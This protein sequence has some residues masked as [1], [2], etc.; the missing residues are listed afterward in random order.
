ML[1]GSNTKKRSNHFARNSTKRPSKSGKSG[2]F[3]VRRTKNGRRTRRSCTPIGGS[4]GLPGRKKSTLPSPPRPTLNICNDKPYQD[5]KKV[6]VAGPFTVE[7]IS[8]HRVLNVGADD[9][10][11][12]PLESGKAK[13][14]SGGSETDFVTMILEN[15]NTAG[16]QQAHKEDKIAFSSR[17]PVARPLCLCRGQLYER[18]KAKKQEKNCVQPS[19]S[20]PSSARSAVPDLV[21]A[22]RRGRRRRFR[23]AD[24]LCVQTTTPF[25]PSSTS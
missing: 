23:R 15:L 8:P 5:N 20:A 13:A 11:L 4:S 19:S 17:H 1:S 16:V 18:R 22:A 14:E 9:E 10:L 2:R 24:R 12:D 3:P 6:R 25:P 21:A 7:S